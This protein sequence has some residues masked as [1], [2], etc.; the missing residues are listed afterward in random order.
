MSSKY[1]YNFIVIRL[2]PN[3][4]RSLGS[5]S[6]AH[7]DC[8]I[9]RLALILEV[10]RI[11]PDQP[12]GPALRVAVIGDHVL[13]DC[14]ALYRSTP[15]P[16]VEKEAEGRGRPTAKAPITPPLSRSDRAQFV[17][18]RA[19]HRRRAPTGSRRDRVLSAMYWRGGAGG[20]RR[21][22]SPGRGL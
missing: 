19:P 8:R 11:H 2:W 1:L 16:A 10:R 15:E 22:R 3:R 5:P 6:Q 9:A 20:R 7:R 14:E 17:C 4:R 12:V 13:Q 21:P 18:R